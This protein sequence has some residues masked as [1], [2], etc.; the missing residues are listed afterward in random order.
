M[1]ISHPYISIPSNIVYCKE[2]AMLIF[3]GHYLEY[4]VIFRASWL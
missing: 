1:K 4:F 2:H 3:A